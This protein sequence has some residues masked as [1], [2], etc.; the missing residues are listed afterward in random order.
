MNVRTE[1][2]GP[3]GRS[4]AVEL[5]DEDGRASFPDWDRLVTNDRFRKLSAKA[6]SLV[7]FYLARE[8]I[9]TPEYARQRIAALKEAMA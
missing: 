9:V 3:N 2:A 7:V 8:N 1:A 6:D 4:I 5:S